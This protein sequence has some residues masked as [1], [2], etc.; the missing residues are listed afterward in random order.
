MKTTIDYSHIPAFTAGVY[1]LVCDATGEK[2][3]GSSGNIRH[4][5]SQHFSNLRHNRHPNELIQALFDKHGQEAF[6]FYMIEAV[7]D[8]EKRYDVE[9]LWNDTGD[10]KL[11]KAENVR[12]GKFSEATKQKMSR[13]RKGRFIGADNNFYGRQHTAETK[14]RIADHFIGKKLP[15]A[16]V[17]K[18]RLANAAEKNGRFLG[19]HIVPWGVFASAKKASAAS[20]PA[21]APKNIS[22]YCRSSDVAITDINYV[23]IPYLRAHFDRSV[24]GKTWGEIGFGYR[25]KGEN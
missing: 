19:H 17:A 20:G 24:V 18:M 13:A 9:Q 1:A 16:T 21:M 14:Q 8:Q 15:E 3:V 22:K 2:Y 4:R 6:S 5:I 11:N 10:F 23:R 12:P 7:D 25:Q